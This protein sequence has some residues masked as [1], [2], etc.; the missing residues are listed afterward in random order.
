MAIISVVI[1]LGVSLFANSVALYRKPISPGI[2]DGTTTRRVPLRLLPSSYLSEV[3][4]IY[5]SYETP[6]RYVGTCDR[7]RSPIRFG[8][9]MFFTMEFVVYFVKTTETGMSAE[10]AQQ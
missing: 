1:L 8:S 4:T 10:V 2:S 3:W 6:M 5:L 7:C 9:L